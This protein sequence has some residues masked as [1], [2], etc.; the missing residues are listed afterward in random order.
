M[1][2][3][4]LIKK[5]LKWCSATRKPRTTEY[6]RCLLY[7]F[8]A[9]VGNVRIGKLVPVD[10]ESFGK[11]FHQVQ[12]VQRLFQ[13]AVD[14]LRILKVNPFKKVKRPPAGQRTRIFD[15]KEL[16][17]YLRRCGR[18][19]RDFLIVMRGTMARPQEVKI[20]SWP[21]LQAPID[22]HGTIED[23]LYAGKAMFV[24]W[25]YKSR[26]RAA[27]PNKPRIIMMT[28]RVGRLLLRL[29]SRADS[30][31]G[32]ILLNDLDMPWTANALR[33][34]MRRLRRKFPALP[35]V[36]GENIVN[37]TMRHTA[38]T[39]ASPKVTQKELSLLLGH[40]SMETTERYQHLRID[41]LHDAMEKIEDVQVRREQRKKRKAA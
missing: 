18:A 33:C 28:R 24:L 7:S 2:L 15:R 20:L 16:V 1:R 27:N 22:W 19:Y 26:E 35:H 39:Y 21:M 14:G 12:A 40:E 9:H 37:Y 32:I 4:R 41:H 30:L 17:Q 5:F 3:K 31:A 38:A 34:R 13:F 8:L 36:T 29:R 23:A 11:T 10:L 25:E 6:Y